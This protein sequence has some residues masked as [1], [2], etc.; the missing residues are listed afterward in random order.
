MT[1]ELRGLGLSVTPSVGNFVLVTFP[2]EPGRTAAEADA[3]LSAHG[4]ILRAVKAYGLPDS[5]RLTIGSEEAN[6]LVVAT[7]A[8]FIAKPAG[9][10]R[11]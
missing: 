4:L 7:L 1:G 2:R 10:D 8:T 5:L 6:R 9:V 11:G 3:Y